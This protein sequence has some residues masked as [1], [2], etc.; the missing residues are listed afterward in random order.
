MVLTPRGQVKLVDFG[1]AKNVMTTEGTTLTRTGAVVGTMAYM[2]PEQLA[3]EA[4]D[5]RADLW[6]LGVL[7]HQGVY[8]RLPFDGEGLARRIF[9]DPLVLDESRRDV[10]ERF[11]CLLVGL[12]QKKPEDRISS[13]AEVESELRRCLRP[14]WLR[15][16]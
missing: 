3:G 5:H 14:R 10:P 11:E 9:N 7:L 13:A 2:A 1:L 4:V 6:S 12:L 8:G 15:W 16:F